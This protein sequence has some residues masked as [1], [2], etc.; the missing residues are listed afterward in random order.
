MSTKEN[1]DLEV[2]GSQI[3]IGCLERPQW[4]SELSRSPTRA[5]GSD[6]GDV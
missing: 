5:M 4:V 3:S 2:L 1:K 6:N